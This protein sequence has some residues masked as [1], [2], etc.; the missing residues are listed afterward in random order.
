MPL[1]RMTKELE[2]ENVGDLRRALATCPDNMQVTDAMGE[3]L[4]LRF[5]EEDANTWLEFE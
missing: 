5:F 4:I 3:L 1:P 2:V